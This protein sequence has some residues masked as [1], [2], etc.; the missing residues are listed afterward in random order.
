MGGVRRGGNGW[1]WAG[2]VKLGCQAGC[3]LDHGWAQWLDSISGTIYIFHI[4][5]RLFYVFL[6]II[7]GEAG[8][9]GRL[10]SHHQYILPF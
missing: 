10:P 6:S 1:A 8:G 2:N 9:P 3:S 5:N 4:W 7:D